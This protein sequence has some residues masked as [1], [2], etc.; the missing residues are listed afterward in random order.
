MKRNG[1]AG[2]ILILFGVL[3][4]LA[5]FD[6]FSLNRFVIALIITLFLSVLFLNKGLIH[7][8][9]KGILSGS[10]FLLISLQLILMRLG[11]FPINDT[12]GFGLVVIN[13]GLANFIYFIMARQKIGNIVAGLIFVLLGA[14]PVA[15]YYD[16]IPYLDLEYYYSTYWPLLLI[17]IGLGLLIDGYI[18]RSQKTVQS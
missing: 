14:P 4:L 11:V 3:L 13:L 10:F 2:W 16:L 6:W 17:L 8:Q 15:G 1:W 12:V 18:K 9:K 5:Q 7:P